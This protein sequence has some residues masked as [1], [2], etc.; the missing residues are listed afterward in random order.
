LPCDTIHWSSEDGDGSVWLYT[1]CGLVQIPRQDLDS[2]IAAADND[3]NAKNTIRATV[4]DISDGVRSHGS[5]GYSPAVAQSVDGRL[6]FLPFDGV[7]IVDPRHLAFNK[8]PPP[9]HVEQ[10]VADHKTYDATPD[11]NGRVRLPA[12]VRDLQIDY[13]GLS[14]A[15]P[16]KVLFRYKLEGW[17]HDWQDVGP[18]RQA[19]YSNLPPRNYTFRVKAC[20]NSGVWNE[21]GTSLDFSIAPAYYQTWWFR[22][23]CAASFLGFLVILHRLRLYQQARQFNMTLEVRVGERTRIARELDDTMLQSFQGVLLK[24]HALTF[25][26]A[27]RPEALERLENLVEEA[28]QAITE[29]REA[30][31]GVRGSTV[32]TNDLA[33]SLTQV[34]QR[35]VAE[36]DG[37]G[38]V[39]FHVEVEGDPRDLH[40]IIR[41]EVYR[42]ASEALRNSFHHSG[43][44]RI[45][46][47]IHYDERQFRV[48]TR[49]NGIGIDHK[50]LDGGGRVGHYGLPGMHERAKLVGGKLTVWSQVNSGTEIELTIPASRA[51]TKPRTPQRLLFTRKG[52]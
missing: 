16:E 13:T 49:D 34:G 27:D 8:L 1:E 29:G 26:L 23:L 21:A 46:V 28:S 45:E 43:A 25:M 18:R 5:G 11:S 32:V 38:P 48:R 7:S 19:F 24:F 6:W 50:I 47:E 4:F 42:I 33:R 31:Q 9:V 17:D 20:N 30:V 36:Q 39:S 2:W 44:A 15:A 40:P 14:L 41:D 51:Y 12:R 35:L 3:K 52:A 22:T 10:I 37:R